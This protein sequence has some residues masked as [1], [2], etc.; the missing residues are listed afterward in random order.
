[1]ST[2]ALERSL[3]ALSFGVVREMGDREA[4][5]RKHRLLE[6][7]QEFQFR[8]SGTAAYRVAWG[9]VPLDFR[10]LFV[11]APA[12]RDSPYRFPT[13]VYGVELESPDPVCVN[14]HLRKWKQDDSGAVLGCELGVGAHIPGDAGDP[15]VPFRG[16]VHAVFSGYGAPLES[17]VDEEE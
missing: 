8:I 2:G 15:E 17:E 14:V 7:E 1:M 3:A 9:V 13:F 6:R 11:D 10:V 4:R 16:F 5:L 12:Q